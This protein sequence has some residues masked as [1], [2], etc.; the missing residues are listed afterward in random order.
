MAT[1]RIKTTEQIHSQR[2]RIFE[3]L[4]TVTRNALKRVDPC[5]DGFLYLAHN[6]GNPKAK[7]LGEQ[8]EQR[9]IRIHETATAQSDEAFM[10]EYPNHSF[11]GRTIDDK[12]V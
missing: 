7:Q 6:W 8:F 4:K 5:T 11:R 10:R 12:I 1:R 3:L 2:L 9:C